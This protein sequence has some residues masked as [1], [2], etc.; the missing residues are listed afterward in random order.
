[1]SSAFSTAFSRMKRSANWRVNRSESSAKFSD[2][3]TSWGSVKR[4]LTGTGASFTLRPTIEWIDPCHRVAGGS[5]VPLR[6]L[7]R[8]HGQS[9]YPPEKMG[10]VGQCGDCGLPLRY[11]SPMAIRVDPA[12]EVP[13]AASEVEPKSPD[14]PAVLE[15]PQK[16]RIP[17]EP[18]P[19]KKGRKAKPV[20]KAER[21]PVP[22]TG[23]RKN[24][25]LLLASWRFWA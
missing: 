15:R 19:A 1:M 16:R 21:S 24:S 17:N 10:L 12:E 13:A 6:L 20:K 2:R 9:P 18:R 25:L 5:H 4:I 7:P 3:T 8:V 14:K 11:A 23:E 22:E